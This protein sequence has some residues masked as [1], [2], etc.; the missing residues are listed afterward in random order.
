MIPEALR[1]MRDRFVLQF[2]RKRYTVE[3]GQPARTAARAGGAPRGAR[4]WYV[5]LGGTAIT[6][7]EARA[8]EREPALRRRVRQWLA[9]HPEL[10]SRDQIVLGGG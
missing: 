2:R 1:V 8:G 10:H 3:R 5:T 7:L 4:S 9:D 6:R